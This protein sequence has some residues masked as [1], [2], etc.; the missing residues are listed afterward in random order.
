MKLRKM[1]K[2]IFGCIVISRLLQ[3]MEECYD[4]FG[5]VRKDF[6]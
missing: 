5:Y 6:N 2:E 4:L 3:L 1:D